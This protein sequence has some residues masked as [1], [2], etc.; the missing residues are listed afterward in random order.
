MKSALYTVVTA[1]FIFLSFSQLSKAQE[2]D[3]TVTVNMEQ[4]PFEARTNV[5]SLESDLKNYINN[6]RFTNVDWQGSKIPVDITIYLSG[7]A[8]NRYSGRLLVVSKRYLEGTDG[9]QSPEIK[10]Y[11]TKWSFEYGLGAYL[12]YNPNTFNE[13]N[14]LIDYYMLLVIG[15]D[16]DTYGEL[17][18]S[19]AFEA[20]KNLVLLGSSYGADGYQTQSNIGDFT[21]FNL[22]SELTNFRYDDLRKLFFSYY[23][24]GL[25]NMAKNKELALAKLDTIIAEMADYKQNKM[26][27]P[28]VLLQAFFDTKAQEIASLFNGYPKQDVFNNLKYLDPSNSS[29]Y[30]DAMNGKINR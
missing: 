3:A 28:S 20:A 2:L 17:E 18:G 30:D 23:V 12:K 8:D 21:R 22:V 14:T 27:G 7:G 13:F 25:D 9:G 5:S 15:F 26:T 24:D 29:L 19:K 11:D 4:L 6:Q 1:I 10:L 16:M